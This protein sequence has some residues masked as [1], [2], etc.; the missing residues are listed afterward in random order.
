MVKTNKITTGKRILLLRMNT[1]YL[2]TVLVVWDQ[3]KV[4]AF[5]PKLRVGLLETQSLKKL[6][7]SMKSMTKW[8]VHPLVAN[9]MH[10]DCLTYGKDLLMVKSGWHLLLN[11]ILEN[12]LWDYYSSVL[13]NIYILVLGI[14]PSVFILG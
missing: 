8:A 6:N 10:A 4:I 7:T 1:L 2:F 13:V 3:N 12:N 9:E 14:K 5:F 11:I